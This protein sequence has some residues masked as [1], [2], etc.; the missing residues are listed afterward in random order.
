MMKARFRRLLIVVAGLLAY[1]A[2]ASVSAASC[3]Y[4]Y[5]PR[6]PKCLR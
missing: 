3:D 2:A 4:F 1:V 5:Q 6:V